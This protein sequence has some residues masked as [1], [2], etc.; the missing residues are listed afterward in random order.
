MRNVVVWGLYWGELPCFDGL[1]IAG[2]V[3]AQDLKYL[4]TT[5]KF[6]TLFCGL[7]GVSYATG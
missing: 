7:V 5:D 4:V 3:R 2:G 6:V 1:G